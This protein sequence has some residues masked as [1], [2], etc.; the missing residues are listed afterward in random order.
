MSG[1]TERIAA[2]CPCSEIVGS[3]SALKD[4]SPEDQLDEFI[5]KYTP[6]IAAQTRAVL[7]KMRASLP[8]AVEL[9]YDNYNALVIGF[10]PSERASDAV[11]SIAVY[12]RWINLF[13]LRG[14]R[15]PDPE[16]LL[17]GSGKSVRRIVV[18]EPNTLDIPA[19]RTLMAHALKRAPQ[20]FDPRQSNRIVIKSISARQRPRR[21]V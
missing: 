14:G 8:G 11:F 12:P 7:A 19:V 1:R 20:P 5:S 6:V 2:S 3:A 10:G 9:V 21:P 17:K 16:R 15:L 4:M 18:N 13:F